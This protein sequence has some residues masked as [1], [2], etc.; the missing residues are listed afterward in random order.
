MYLQY[1]ILH[2]CENEYVVEAEA[3]LW[4]MFERSEAMSIILYSA[5]VAG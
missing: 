4:F 5:L 1:S 2:V 3:S